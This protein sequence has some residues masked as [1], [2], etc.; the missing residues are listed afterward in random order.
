MN[1]RTYGYVRVSSREQNE[2]RQMTAMREFGI[3]EEN[4]VVE[5]QS[6]KDF[7]RPLYLR[8]LRVLRPGDVLV[9]KSIDR[10]GRNYTEILEQWGAI[11]KERE[12][13]TVVLDMPLLD[14]R[15]GRDLTGKLIADIVLQLLSY[16]AQQERENIRQRQAEGIAAAKSRG[17]A[18]ARRGWPCRRSSQTWRTCGGRESSPPGQPPGSWASP[19]RPS[20]AGPRSCRHRLSEEQKRELS[21]FLK[22][23][24]QK[25]CAPLRQAQSFQRSNNRIAHCVYRL[26]KPPGLCYSKR[27]DPAASGVRKRTVFQLETVPAY[28][29]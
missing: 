9:V 15:Q 25:D 3:A 8:L 16:V 29:S 13:A 18:S 2:I 6:G 27:A 22:S 12:I 28:S 23:G 24:N 17:S 20:S 4:I 26:Y 5:K 21:G 10:L 14:T 7:R 19:I 11:T 1:G